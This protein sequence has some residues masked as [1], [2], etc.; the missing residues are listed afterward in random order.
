MPTYTEQKSSATMGNSALPCLCWLE[1]GVIEL[2]L[3]GGLVTLAYLLHFTEI[4]PVVQQGFICQDLALSK[5]FA[6]PSEAVPW[7]VLYAMAFGA[8]V[9]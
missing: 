7:P 4:I 8:P 3:F 5:P 2:F 1:V 9:E 6:G